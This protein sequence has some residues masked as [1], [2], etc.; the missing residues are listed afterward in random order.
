MSCKMTRKPHRNPAVSRH[1]GKRA[2]REIQNWPNN[3][4]AF[5][6]AAAHPAHH[7]APL[8]AKY[9]ARPIQKP[10][11][12]HPGRPPLAAPRPIAPHFLQQMMRAPSIPPR[13]KI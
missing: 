8:F 12:L 6:L 2:S 4:G 7:F 11:Q 9:G 5:P 1:E 3:N 10:P 13:L